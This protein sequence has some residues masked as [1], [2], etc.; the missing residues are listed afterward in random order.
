[1]C[2]LWIENHQFEWEYQSNKSKI[3]GDIVEVES[4]L[5]QIWES[6]N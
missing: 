4:L 2:K 5:C 6:A 1:M 3:A